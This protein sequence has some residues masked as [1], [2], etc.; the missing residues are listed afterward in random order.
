MWCHLAKTFFWKKIICQRIF[1]DFETKKNFYGEQLK[2]VKAPPRANHTSSDCMMCPPFLFLQDFFF[3]L[4]LFFQRHIFFRNIFC[5][6]SIKHKDIKKFSRYYCKIYSTRWLM[7]KVF[8]S[9]FFFSWFHVCVST[10]IRSVSWII[11][12]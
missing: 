2:K 5:K 3:W 4:Q 8:H 9:V 10:E 11:E 7:K 12:K 1:R 6:Q